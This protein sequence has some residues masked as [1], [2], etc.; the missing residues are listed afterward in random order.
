MRGG[1]RPRAPRPRSWRP[2]PRP[3]GGHGGC[4]RRRGGLPPVP[5][6]GG[7]RAAAASSSTRTAGLGEGKSEKEGNGLTKN[8]LSSGKEKVNVEVRVLGSVK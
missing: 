2:S 6:Q 7:D 3:G 1:K 4:G 5:L 8:K